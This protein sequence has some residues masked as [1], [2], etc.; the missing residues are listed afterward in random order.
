MFFDP[1]RVHRTH[2]HVQEAPLLSLRAPSGGSGPGIISAEVLALFCLPQQ[3]LSLTSSPLILHIFGD[4][5][6]YALNSY[7]CVERFLVC[8][9]ASIVLLLDCPVLQIL[10]LGG[11]TVR[12]S[13]RYWPATDNLLNAPRPRTPC[14]PPMTGGG[15]PQ[16]TT[17]EGEENVEQGVFLTAT[18]QNL[19]LRAL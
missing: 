6:V 4:S 7:D 10:M 18:R 3:W 14:T 16:E 17:R 12:H 13:G 19:E 2:M 5:F 8:I 15:H 11:L 1:A 9:C